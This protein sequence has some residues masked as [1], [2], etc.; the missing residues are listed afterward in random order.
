[1]RFVKAKRVIGIWCYASSF[2][3]SVN[4][5]GF[6]SSMFIS[7]PVEA[8]INNCTKSNGE[9]IT[10]EEIL[11]GKR[12]NKLIASDTPMSEWKDKLIEQADISIDVVKFNYRG[13]TYLG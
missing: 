5:N 11:F 8:L 9:I 10:R 12:L 4:L 3:K 13:L 6:F 1:M 7:N 2:A